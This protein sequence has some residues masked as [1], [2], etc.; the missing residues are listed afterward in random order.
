MKKLGIL[1]VLTFLIVGCRQPMVMYV[2][3]LNTTVVTEIGQ[4][5]FT[6]IYAYAK[7]KQYVKLVNA[8]D[9]RKYNTYILGNP[10]DELDG[11]KCALHN[12]SDSLLDYNCDGYFTH[13]RDGSKLNKP[14]KY[15][16][17]PV[18]SSKLKLTQDAFKYE[19][20]YQGKVGN[21]LKITFQ[22]FMRGRDGQFII[23]DAFN[24]TIVYEL[25]KNGEAII[26]F[27]GLRIK[28]LKATN[29]DISYKVLKDYD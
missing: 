15:K 28:V 20:L 21:K 12:R 29:A 16:I 23:R 2:P 14:V 17:I 19:V 26:G 22:E 24:Q 5:M 7:H 10:F 4:N 1:V 25:D 13:L 3:N 8:D 11:I 6:K 27:K 9:R 18:P